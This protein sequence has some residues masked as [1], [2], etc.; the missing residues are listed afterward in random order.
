MMCARGTIGYIALEVFSRNFGGVSHKADVYNF[1]MMVLEMV[2]GKH[3]KNVQVDCSSELYF[4]HWIY[5][6]LELNQ[7]FGLLCIKNESDRETVRKMTVVGLWCIQTNPSSRPPMSK[8]VEMLEGSLESLELPP[9][10]FLHSS[11]TS[12]THYSTQ[13]S[14][15]L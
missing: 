11:P 5:K 8:V 14:E 6:Q 9:K 3:N 4:P 7:D 12:P 10:P 13:T 15:T 1:G 2:G